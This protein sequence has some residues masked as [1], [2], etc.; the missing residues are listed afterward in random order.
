MT[1][2]V[3]C[4]NLS[5]SRQVVAR[6]QQKYPNECFIPA[7]NAFSHL[8]N[9]KFSDAEIS[10]IEIDLLSNCDEMLICG[11]V[12]DVI[13]KEIDFCKKVDIEVRYIED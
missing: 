9:G 8:Y 6:I 2:F 1:I 13:R 10:E 7:R 11:D 5:K 12:D 4:R 3:V